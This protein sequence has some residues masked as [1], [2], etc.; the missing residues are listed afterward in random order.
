ML[1]T[2]AS[3]KLPSVDRVVVRKSERTLVLMHGGNV[4]RSYHIQLGLNPVGQKERAGDFRT[5]EGTL[6]ARAAQP[7][8]RLLPVAEGVLSESARTC[9]ARTRIT[10]TPAARS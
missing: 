3:D 10:G 4:V 1:T 2:P 8:Q 9:A 6:P 5:P 7:A